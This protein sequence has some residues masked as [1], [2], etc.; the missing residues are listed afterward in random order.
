MK[1]DRFLTVVLVMG[2]SMAMGAS[3]SGAQSEG[4]YVPFQGATKG[5]SSSTPTPATP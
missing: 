2:L 5:S 4:K 1:I 3:A